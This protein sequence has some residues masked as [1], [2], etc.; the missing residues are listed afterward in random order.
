M[1]QSMTGYGCGIA[2]NERFRITVEIKSINSKFIEI[3]IK[4]PSHY[5]QQEVIIRN[6]LTTKLLRGKVTVFIQ[7]EKLTSSL[8]GVNIN[9]NNLKIYADELRLLCKE[10]N[11]PDALSINTLLTLPNVIQET[12]VR[13]EE[14]EI[15]VLMTALQSATEEIIINRRNEG[16]ILHQDMIERCDTIEQYLNEIEPLESERI[17]TIK[18]RMKTGMQELSDTF[19]MSEDRF[20]QEIL[21]YIEKYDINEEKIRLRA[22]LKSLRETLNIDLEN[23]GRKLYFIVQEMHREANTLGVKSYDAK[24]QNLVV[25]I[26]EEIEKLKE[27]LMNIS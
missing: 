13:S 10:L 17:Q 27:Q 14:D 12:A 22:H 15:E 2:S 9:K 1:I 3:F 18:Q 26:K 19:S 11:L 7:V 24:I 23:Q 6:H 20:Q 5:F 16:S 21:F 8:D 4:Q 25:G